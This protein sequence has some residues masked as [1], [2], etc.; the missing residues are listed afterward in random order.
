MP[1]LNYAQDFAQH[2]AGF[3]FMQFISLDQMLYLYSLLF[4]CCFNLFCSMLPLLLKDGLLLPYV[5][6]SLAF[7]Y[8][9]VYLLSALERTSEE[10][11]RLGPCHKRTQYCLSKHTLSLLIKCTVSN[12]TQIL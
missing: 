7:L 12:K 8:F 2:F 4:C 11:L 3:L 6:T 5:V 1:W 9:S 10:E